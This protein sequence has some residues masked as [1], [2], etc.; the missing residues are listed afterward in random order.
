LNDTDWRA[1]LCRLEQSQIFARSMSQLR[2]LRFLLE[3]ADAE[4]D[5]AKETYIGAAYFGRDSTY[6]PRYDSIV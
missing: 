4:G 1:A 2:L 6:D 5:G 3:H